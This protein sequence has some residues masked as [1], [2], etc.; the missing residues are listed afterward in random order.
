MDVGSIPRWP[1]I[2]ILFVAQRSEQLA[3]NH[4]VAGSNPVEQAN[5]AYGLMAR[6]RDCLSR[7]TGSTPVT[8]AHFL[9]HQESRAL[10][11]GY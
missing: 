3:V 6:I 1:A 7:G 8:L 5:S 4:Q 9:H 11:V 10:G 2:K